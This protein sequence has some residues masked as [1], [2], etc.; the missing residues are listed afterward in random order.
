MYIK[1]S[2]SI[3]ARFFLAGNLRAVDRYSLENIH[4]SL[5]EL[6][7]EGK[8]TLEKIPTVKTIKGWIGR[9]SASFKKTA[10]EQALVESNKENKE[11]ISET[12]V[13]RN[14]SQIEPRKHQKKD[15]NI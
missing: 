11:N 12:N 9:Y 6:V 15:Q 10:S 5:L 8:L 3:L 14:S 7:E 13:K 4:V 2:C 1:K